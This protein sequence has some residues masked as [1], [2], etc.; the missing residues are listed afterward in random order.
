MDTASIDGY[1]RCLAASGDVEEC[2]GTAAEAWTVTARGGLRSGD[3]CL[4]VV[5]GKPAMQTC[6]GSAAE[7]WNYTLAGNLVNASEKECLSA[8]PTVGLQPDLKQIL[9]VMPCGHNLLS[10][11]WSLPNSSEDLS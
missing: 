10:Q 6:D 1:T 3:E 9:I 5:L 11:I 7:R 4:A 8:D 2:A